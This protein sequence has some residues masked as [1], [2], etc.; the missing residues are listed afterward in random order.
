MT[1]KRGAQFS[2]A[3]LAGI[4]LLVTTIIAAIG[5]VGAGHN[6]NDMPDKAL[7]APDFSYMFFWP[8][9]MP[10]AF[11]RVKVLRN[12]IKYCVLS[13]LLL[14][15][16]VLFA[17]DGIDKT[18]NALGGRIYLGHPV[19]MSILAYVLAVGTMLYGTLRPIRPTVKAE[20]QNSPQNS[21]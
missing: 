21:T 1:F 4:L 6:H 2:A 7:F 16:Y 14:T 13:Q 11:S 10:L 18:M 19:I 3:G 9:L 8:L 5:G 12:I 17:E 20:E 15:L